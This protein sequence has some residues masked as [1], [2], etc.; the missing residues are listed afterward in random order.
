MT[1]VVAKNHISTK[2]LDL[3]IFYKNESKDEM[4]TIRL[5]TIIGCG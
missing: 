4:I 5:V 2:C 1:S 3:S